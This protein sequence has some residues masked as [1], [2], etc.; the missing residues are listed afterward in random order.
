MNYWIDTHAHLF[1]EE[2]DDDIDLVIERCIQENV[3]KIILPN[4]DLPTLH[5]VKLLSEKYPEICLPT[6][7]LHPCDV[8]SDFRE[9]LEEIKSW[10]YQPIIFPNKK[11]YGIGETGLDYHWDIS[12]KNEQQEAL[13]RQIEWAK[14]LELPIILH[15]RD[16][17]QDCIDII[18]EYQGKHLKGVFHCFGGT[19][20]QAK[21]ILGIENFYI[22]VDGPLTYKKSKLT[23]IF[24]EIPLERI[25]LE[26]DSPFLPPALYRGKRNE[27]SYIPI[28]AQ[29]LAEVKSLN[30]ETIQYQ[31]TK[32]AEDLFNLQHTSCS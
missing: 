26:T 27:S 11:I 6:V 7:G 8:K 20:E 5:R 30:L 23:S 17:E 16:A 2:F 15:S 3:R 10:A 29:K 25:L 18:K 9:V 21:Q 4:I 19:L 1:S 12:Y 28:I 22:G 14:E 31:T 13:R 24:E 32:N